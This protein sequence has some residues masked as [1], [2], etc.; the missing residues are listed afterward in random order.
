MEKIEVVDEKI[1]LFVNGFT[2]K[3]RGGAAYA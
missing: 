3:Y 2:N 1:E